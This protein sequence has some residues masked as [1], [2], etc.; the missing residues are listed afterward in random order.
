M[1][2]YVPRL[3][4][5]HR[6][7]HRPNKILKHRRVRRCVGHAD[8]SQH[9]PV[10]LPFALSRC[11]DDCRDVGRQSWRWTAASRALAAVGTMLAYA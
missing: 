10:W 7:P 9:S 5:L 8:E 3:P 1:N 11:N 2:G 4:M 6:L